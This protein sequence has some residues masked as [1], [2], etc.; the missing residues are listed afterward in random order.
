MVVIHVIGSYQVLSSNPETSNT[1][2]NFFGWNLCLKHEFQNYFLLEILSF[3]RSPGQKVY[4]L[5]CPADIRHAGLW[6][7]GDCDGE[8][9]AFHSIY[10]TSTCHSLCLCW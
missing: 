2:V 4:K 3:V 8:K 7:A 9:V 6:S 1:L 10:L 5:C